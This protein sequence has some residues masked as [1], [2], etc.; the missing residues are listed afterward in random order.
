MQGLES[1]VRCE[2]SRIGEGRRGD[3]SRQGEGS[4]R[5]EGLR[6]GNGK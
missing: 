3:V 2:E 6:Q 5:S 4:R 1:K